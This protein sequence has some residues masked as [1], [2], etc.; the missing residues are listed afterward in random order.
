MKPKLEGFIVAIKLISGE[1]IIGRVVNEQPNLLMISQPLSFIMHPNP[2]SPNQA[3][4]SFAP[5]MIGIRDNQIVSLSLDKILFVAEARGDASDQYR[6]AI[7]DFDSEPV[8]MTNTFSN[9][10]NIS[11]DMPRKYN[12]D[13][14]PPKMGTTRNDS[15]G[16]DQSHFAVGKTNPKGL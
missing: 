1:E 10:Q 15:R 16:I 2:K 6:Q 11:I 4:V 9:D 13:S 3:M 14:V 12:Q 5:W 8:M 7:G